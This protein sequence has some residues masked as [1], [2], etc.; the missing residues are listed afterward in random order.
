MNAT[1]KSRTSLISLFKSLFSSEIDIEENEDIKLPE[2]LNKVW[3]GLDNTA[4]NIVAEP[5]TS[6]TSNNSKKGGIRKKYVT[7]E[8][9]T[10]KEMSTEKLEKM[11]ETLNKDK[12]IGD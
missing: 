6:N 9:K 5:I 10:I 3:E 2:E 11:I 8:I 4:K 1:A 12:E 7:P